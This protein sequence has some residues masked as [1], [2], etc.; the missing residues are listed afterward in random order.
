MKYV[1]KIYGEVEF[2]G[3]IEEIIR[4]NAFQR[5][6][7]VHQGGPIF[8]VNPKV[9][10][11]RFEHSIGVMLIIKKLG[12][13]IEEQIAGLLHD[14]SHT[15]FSH[16]IDYVL[17]IE[18]EDYHEKRYDKVLKD[19]DLNAAFD[20]HHIDIS[21]FNDLEKFKLLEYPLPHLSADRID[22]TLRDMF[23]IGKISQ[24]EIF[25]FISGLATFENR[26]VLK[27]KEYG[28]WFQEKYNFLTTRYFASKENI[29]INV[30][31]K[32]IVKECLGNGI[33]KEKDFFED[34]FYLID[35]INKK[36]DLMKW[37]DKVRNNGLENEKLKTKKRIVDP[38]VLVNNK[39]LKLSEMK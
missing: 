29:E 5:L 8:L 11:T 4:T 25:W 10:H 30:I 34:D 14:I 17:E 35:K 21:T 20:K 18:G 1:D 31:M 23:Q 7:K 19:S 26:I 27:S 24:E 36:S 9:N 6:S 12:G 2:L 39:I 15:A 22:Y 16:L 3:I 32:Q 38:E 28:K 33:I 37:I 13:N